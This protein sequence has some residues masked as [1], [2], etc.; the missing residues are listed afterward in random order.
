VRV[1]ELDCDKQLVYH[2]R[3]VSGGIGSKYHR[4]K[5]SGKEPYIAV[6]LIEEV[7]R[8]GEWCLDFDAAK[9][10]L[11]PPS[12]INSA[13]IM[14]ADNSEPMVR[15]K[16]AEHI[17]LKGI[18]FEGRLGN[19][20]EVRGGAHVAVSECTVRNIG[21]DAV[22]L[23]RG[24]N[25]RVEGCDIYDV[26]AQGVVACGGDRK[27]LQPAGHVIA[28]N[29][30]Y[31][32]ARTKTIYAAG[33]NIGYG[34]SY[35]AN[36]DSVGITVC[37]N[38]I[39]DTPHVGVLYGGNNHLLEYNEIHHVALVSNDMG[40]FYTVNDWT[41][42]GNVLRYNFVHSSPQAEGVYCDDGDSGDIIYGNSFYKLHNGVFIGGGHD[43]I[44]SNNVAIACGHGYHVDSRGVSRKYDLTN[45]T[46]V[47]RVKSVDH[48]N[49]PWSTAYP[50][51]VNILEFNP[52]LPTGT[53]FKN[54]LAVNCEKT[55]NIKGAKEHFKFCSF[56]GNA[57]RSVDGLDSVE[58]VRKYIEVNSDLPIEKVGL[59]R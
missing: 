42:R 32:F 36:P 57:G 35:G 10:Y 23:Y 15:F 51:M 12:D 39:H 11:W 27:T 40:G 20:V 37:N 33:I 47:G 56:E 58:A 2:S 26:G 18:L 6:N 50:E 9:L 38:L 4:P 45:R 17:T 31:R 41:T 34:S 21:R 49:P 59:R 7:D 22:V 44:V 43:N 54:N 52:Q 55:L 5:G 29:H 53:S 16:D 30:I 25:H 14:L 28:N 8:P 1:K 48:K 19:A 13:R 46:K 24:W 3:Y